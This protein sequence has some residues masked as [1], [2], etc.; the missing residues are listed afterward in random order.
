MKSIYK[1]LYHFIGSDLIMKLKIFYNFLFILILFISHK[2]PSLLRSTSSKKITLRV[3][4]FLLVPVMM[5]LIF[6]QTVAQAWSFTSENGKEKLDSYFETISSKN[7]IPSTIIQ[8]PHI[9]LDI[10]TSF[11]ESNNE[12]VNEFVWKLIEKADLYLDAKPLSVIEKTENPPSG[13]IHDFYSLSAYEWPN[14][15]SSDGLP[16]VSRDGVIN[17]EIYSISDKKN[18]DE[19]VRMVKVLALTYYFTDDNRYA[20]KARDLLS[21]WFLNEDTY[22]NPHLK[23]AETIRGKNEIRAQG[24]MEGRPLT[25]ITDAIRLLQTSPYWTQD[26]QQGM[27]S[28]FRNYLDWLINSDSGKEEKNK[29][30]NHGTYYLVQVSAIGLFLNEIQIVRDLLEN[31]MK[32]LGSAP[33]SEISSLIAVKILY[34]GRQPFELRRTNSLDYSLVNLLGMFTLANIGERVGLDM[35][36]NKIHGAGLQNALDYLIPFLKGE[37]IWPYKQINEVKNHVL[38]DVYCQGAL[39]YSNNRA[40]LEIYQSTASALIENIYFPMCNQMID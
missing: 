27:E 3:K 24:I 17:P 34:D 10:K 14:P 35:W 11:V 26:V 23:Y 20:E 18:M 38:S 5:L 40:Y 31:T 39:H 22:M 16:Y 2:V 6:N 36:N 30:N 8:D 19:M 12:V 1:I 37:K 9:L 15:D 28:W 7:K 25:E 32:D 29:M 13:N 21:I 4:K 33:L